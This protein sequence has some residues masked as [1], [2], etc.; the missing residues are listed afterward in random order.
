M[1]KIRYFKSLNYF[2]K[3]CNKKKYIFFAT[4]FNVLLI[5]SIKVTHSEDFERFTMEKTRWDEMRS[6]MISDAA[7]PRLW[8]LNE[9]HRIA[10]EAEQSLPGRI[11]GKHRSIDARRG[12]ADT[13]KTAKSTIRVSFYLHEKE[14][15]EMSA[16]DNARW[17][18]R[19]AVIW[20]IPH[21]N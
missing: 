1:N 13:Q 6:K 10:D 11:L 12:D 5:I 18:L 2:H 8:R 17:W 20:Y 21:S 7:K 9:L 14:R 4:K 15:P 3:V 19:V 16:P